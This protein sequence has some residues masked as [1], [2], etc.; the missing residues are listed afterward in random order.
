MRRS[1]KTE[2]SIIRKRVKALR[3]LYGSDLLSSRVSDNVFSLVREKFHHIDSIGCY[4]AIGSEVNLRVL[5]ARLGSH[6]LQVPV[7]TPTSMFFEKEVQ[8]VLVPMVAFD[9][10]GNRLG[11]GCGYYDRFLRGK[12]VVKVGIAYS[13]QYISHLPTSDHDEPMDYVVTERGIHTFKHV[14]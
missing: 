8:I 7:V 13:F 10:L 9:K 6:I 1:V 14:C 3:F 4:N 5:Y 11:Y 12:S 2:K